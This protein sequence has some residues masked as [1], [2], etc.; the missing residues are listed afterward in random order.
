MI[1]LKSFNCIALII[2]LMSLS[3]AAC[4]GKKPF[5]QQ[6]LSTLDGKKVIELISPNALA[7][8]SE[9]G[10]RIIGAYSAV[11]RETLEINLTIDGKA[12]TL[13]YKMTHLGLEAE[14]GTVYYSEFA[15]AEEKKKGTKMAKAEERKKTV[16]YKLLAE[17]AGKLLVDVPAGC[18]GM[19]NHFEEGEID[20][21]PVHK[22][23]LDGFKIDK[24]EVTQANYSEVIGRNPS[25]NK[26][27]PEC[28]VNKVTWFEAKE[29]CERVG[30]RLPTEAEWEY[31]AT[32]GGKKVMYS[33]SSDTL[34]TEKANYDSDKPVA[35]A[36]YA[37]NALGVHDMAGN[38][39]EWIED[40]YNRTYYEKSPEKNPIWNESGRLRVLRGGSWKRIDYFLRASARYSSSPYYRGSDIGFRCV[41]SAN[42]SSPTPPKEG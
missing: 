42:A 13:Y 39:Y 5:Q 17:K 25:A 41:G 7:W 21:K 12:Q 37:A 6:R 23:C 28:P 32:A 27:C 35:V 19:G 3:V 30:K 10:V 36:K 31:V 1:K 40:F 2:A 4:T 34:D 9:S 38:V 15:L 33:N 26:D 18:F 24:H 14:D 11:D 20:E 29:Y 8:T 22:V 16:D